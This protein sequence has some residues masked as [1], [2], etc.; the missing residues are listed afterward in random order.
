MID[1]KKLD[2]A[3]AVL[4]L[5]SAGKAHLYHRVAAIFTYKQLLRTDATPAL[6]RLTETG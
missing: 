6:V 3:P 4:A 1:L 2:Q 5:A